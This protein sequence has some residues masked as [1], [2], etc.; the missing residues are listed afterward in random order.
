MILAGQSLQLGRQLLVPGGFRLPVQVIDCLI[1][2][3]RAE[4]GGRI[5]LHAAQTVENDPDA[6]QKEAQQQE[7]TGK[8]GA[9]PGRQ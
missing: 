2:R 8:G 4:A 7:L 3:L 5:F 9:V 1:S 6:E